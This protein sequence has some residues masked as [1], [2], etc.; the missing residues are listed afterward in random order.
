MYYMIQCTLMG[1]T[2]LVVCVYNIQTYIYI[3]L[4]KYGTC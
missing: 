1:R 3:E 2:I 4:E